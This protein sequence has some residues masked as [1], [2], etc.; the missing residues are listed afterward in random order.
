MDV[1][2]Q[3]LLKVCLFVLDDV[4]VFYNLGLFYVQQYCWLFVCEILFD[5]V[6]CLL[7]FVEVCLQVVYVCYVC[8]DNICQEVMFVGVVDWLG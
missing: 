5:V 7:D 1:V 6:D 3:V 2:E 8:V 4:D